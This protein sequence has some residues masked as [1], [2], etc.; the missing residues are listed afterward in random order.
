[1]VDQSLRCMTVHVHK[2]NVFQVANKVESISAGIMR[3]HVEK[4]LGFDNLD[5]HVESSQR[6]HMNVQLVRDVLRL[7]TRERGLRKAQ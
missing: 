5:G 2:T 7:I 3:H 6:L 4:V 1:M